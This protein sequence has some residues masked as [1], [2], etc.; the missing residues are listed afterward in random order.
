MSGG[1]SVNTTTRPV[2]DDLLES[3]RWE[4]DRLVISRDRMRRAAEVIDLLRT[5]LVR[6]RAV[7]DQLAEAVLLHVAR[8]G[9]GSE[10][11]ERQVRAALAA[12]VALREDTNQ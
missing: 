1:E 12:V 3:L 4:A 2:E 8:T 11:A 9:W 7:T 5:A 6:E 10:G